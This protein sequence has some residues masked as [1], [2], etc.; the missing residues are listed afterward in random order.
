MGLLTLQSDNPRLSYALHKRPDQA[1]CR[2]IKKGVATLWFTNPET[3]L[4]YFVDEPCEVSFRLGRDS[5]Y[6]DL[7][8]Y[9]SSLMYLNMIST[10][11]KSAMSGSPD[12]V[13][14]SVSLTFG[15]LVLAPAIEKW[16]QRLLSD[17]LVLEKETPEQRAGKVRLFL[18]PEPGTV[19]GLL[20]YATVMLFLNALC[21][22]EMQCADEDSV[23]RH[24]RTI[25]ELDFPYYLR[26]KFVDKAISWR[27]DIFKRARDLLQTSVR[28]KE[29]RLNLGGSQK[30]RGAFIREVLSR[31]HPGT[32]LDVG[33]GEAYH[34]RDILRRAEYIGMDI[35]EGVL[36]RARERLSKVTDAGRKWSLHN[37]EGEAFAAARDAEEGG[38]SVAILCTEVIE[39]MEKEEARSLME[40]LLSQAWAET[41]IVTTPNA[42]FN[43]HLPM[44]ENFRHHDHHWEMTMEEFQEFLGRLGNRGGWKVAHHHV[45]DTVDGQGLTLGAVIRRSLEPE[46]SLFN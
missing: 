2:K 40:R 25:A 19:K 7:G 22:G 35:D 44:S 20:Q 32:V 34:A 4:M 18:A 38:S 26:S 12:D 28:Y 13:P 1:L 24:A 30:Q 41:I 5:S 37:N 11:F 23:L 14:A 10:F 9:A 29:L 39:H 15:C 6:I 31:Y 36:A 43:K 27:E 17:V 16:F 3:V 21:T 42:T 8:P 33:C 45:G 46:L